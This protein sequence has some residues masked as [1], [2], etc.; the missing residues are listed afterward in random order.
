MKEEKDRFFIPNKI[1]VG[2]QERTDTF[3]GKL[4]YII[5][6]DETGK[7]R[8]E[9][10]WN[11]WRNKSIPDDEFE[12]IPTE[13]FYLNKAVGGYK[14]SW[15]YRMSY[16]RIYDPRGFEFEIS[17]DNLLWIL[18][19]CECVKG[20]KLTGKFVYSWLGTDL[21]LLPCD[22]DEYDESLSAS[23]KMFDSTG[24]KASD[25]V[26]GALYK[27]KYLSWYISSN[28]KD[29]ESK[30]SCI[31]LGNFK[32]A[33]NLGKGYETKPIFY[34]KNTDMAFT[35]PKSSIKFMIESNFINSTELKEITHRFKISAYSYDFWK[36][37]SIVKTFK[38]VSDIEFP[39]MSKNDTVIFPNSWQLRDNKYT[40]LIDSSG[41]IY[42]LRPLLTCTTN[43]GYYGT[44]YTVEYVQYNFIMSKI[45]ITPEK[46][47]DITNKVDLGKPAFYYKSL[48]TQPSFNDIY[49]DSKVKT[50]PS[51]SFPDNS[52]QIVLGYETEDGYISN[53]IHH[54]MRFDKL[55]EL[56]KLEYFPLP[57]KL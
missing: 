36:T 21:V 9:T 5:Y 40:G 7:L 8:K 26:P 16:C 56:H 6:Y 43:S 22:S 10:S 50:A 46:L 13:G 28:R 53:S 48:R 30:D 52:K 19:Y 17:I 47:V 57:I 35:L 49:P 23:T 12:N 33:K 34:D 45:S 42:L 55:Y 54:I 27:V 39:G 4:S 51:T 2:Y 44:R 38:D 32:L 1:K 31:F 11:S 14:Y 20:K 3:T 37:E 29:N 25:L 24:L 41:E 18:N 15:N